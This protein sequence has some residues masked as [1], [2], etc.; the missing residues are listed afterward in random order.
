MVVLSIMFENGILDAR[1][2]RLPERLHRPTVRDAVP[3]SAHLVD[4]EA[5]WIDEQHRVWINDLA[6]LVYYDHDCVSDYVRIIIFDEGLVIDVTDSQDADGNIRQFDATPFS[7]HVDNENFDIGDYQPIIAVITTDI[8]LDQIK[9]LF[10]ARY[11]RRLN[12]K[13]VSGIANNSSTS[14][15]KTKRKVT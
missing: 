12:G 6:P 9:Q 3:G 4:I 2:A 11:D 8:E 7:D 5:L 14:S 15:K 1:H 10:K 13:A